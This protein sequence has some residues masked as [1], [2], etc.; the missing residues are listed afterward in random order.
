M[1]GKVMALLE[2]NPTQ[3]VTLEVGKSFQHPAKDLEELLKPA[4]DANLAFIREAGKSVF[5]DTDGK[6]RV[7]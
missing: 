6:G 3:A 1:D 4:V 2:A 5:L 7:R